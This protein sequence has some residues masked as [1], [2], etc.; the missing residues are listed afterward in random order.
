MDTRPSYYEILK[1]SPKAS[2]SDVKRAY[3]SLAK[4]FHPDRN[5]QNRRMAELRFRLISEAYAA[6][7]TQEK[8][9]EYNQ[10]LRLKA[11]N[12]NSGTGFFSQIGEI[13]WPNKTHK[14]SGE[15]AWVK[16][17]TKH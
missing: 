14:K 12:D 1:I 2:D 4:K 11:Q 6:I 7:K 3:H 9:L 15:T 16:I 13:F 17:F 10:S 5:P 8:R